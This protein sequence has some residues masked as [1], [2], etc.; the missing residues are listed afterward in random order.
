[1]ERN[2]IEAQKAFLESAQ[3]VLDMSS[4]F[5]A[6]SIKTTW[7]CRHGEECDLCPQMSEGL[8]YFGVT[9]AVIGAAA[10]ADKSVELY[11]L[12]N[13]WAEKNLDEFPKEVAAR[14]LYKTE[15]GF[16]DIIDEW[17]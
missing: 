6:G 5:L 11:E 10:V 4:Q 17:Q 14:G 2:L 8:N 13:S 15:A 9:I 7:N 16:P 3:C 12:I 1:M